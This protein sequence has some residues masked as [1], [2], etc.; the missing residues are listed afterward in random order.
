MTSD[1]SFDNLKIA[2]LFYSDLNERSDT[3]LKEH[4]F[5]RDEIEFGMKEMVSRYGL[6][7]IAELFLR[8]R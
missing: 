2:L 5:S 1:G 8:E 6:D 3:F 4:D 7:H